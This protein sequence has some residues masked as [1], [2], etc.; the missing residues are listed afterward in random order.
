MNKRR[1][2]NRPEG[3]GGIGLPR[4]GLYCFL[5]GRRGLSAI[6]L[7]A[8]AFFSCARAQDAR[9]EYSLSS[10]PSLCLYRVDTKHG[11]Q[12][13]ETQP[14]LKSRFELG[15]GYKYRKRGAP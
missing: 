7:I 3:H 6:I 12:M 13:T 14:W 9:G 2:T 8:C 11:S 15:N 4:L 10:L 1:T 5:F